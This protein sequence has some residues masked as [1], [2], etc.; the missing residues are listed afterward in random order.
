MQ[1]LGMGESPVWISITIVIRYSS[2]WRIV[3]IVIWRTVW[4]VI[5]IVIKYSS[6]WRIVWIVIWRTV[7]IVI[8]IVIRSSSW[9]IGPK[10]PLQ[11]SRSSSILCIWSERK[12]KVISV[13]NQLNWSWPKCH[14]WLPRQWQI[15]S[16]GNFFQFHLSL[17][18]TTVV[19]HMSVFDDDDDDDDNDDDG[20]DGNDY[21]DV[22]PLW[23]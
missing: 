22:L 18:Q 21:N 13:K 9:R 3:W 6:S 12:T 16:G 1:I 15:W 19:S 4:I 23:Y 2:S 20:C 8:T 10:F 17:T 14:K 7:W 5:T 11:S